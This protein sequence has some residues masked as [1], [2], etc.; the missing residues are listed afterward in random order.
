MVITFCG[1]SDFEKVKGDEE[2]LLNYI[3]KVANK[4][5]VDFYLGGYGNFDNFALS[6]VKLYKKEHSDAKQ[7]LSRHI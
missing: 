3:E 2:R 4:E 7:F 6:C 1:H 5:Q